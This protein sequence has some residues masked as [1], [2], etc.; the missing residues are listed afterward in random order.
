MPILCCGL[1]ISVWVCVCV[2]LHTGM[3]IVRA[4]IHADTHRHTSTHRHIHI[5][6]L[7]LLGSQNEREKGFVE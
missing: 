7:F 1:C 2:L 5:D 3:H 4:C 6:S